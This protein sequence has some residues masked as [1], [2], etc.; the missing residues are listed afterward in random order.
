MQPLREHV[1]EARSAR[2]AAARVE[3]AN[4]ASARV[5]REICR[6]SFDAG[7]DLLATTLEHCVERRRSIVAL[8]QRLRRIRREAMLAL[9]IFSDAPS[10]HGDV[11]CEQRNSVI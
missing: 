6:G 3:R 1:G 11:A 5:L 10:A 9:E 2:T 4:C 7:G 8:N